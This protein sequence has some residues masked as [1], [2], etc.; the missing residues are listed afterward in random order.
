MTTDPREIVARGYDA[1]AEAYAEWASHSVTDPGRAEYEDH[2]CAL[3]G[4]G[5]SVLELGCGGGGPTTA[6]LAER[7]Q[8][9]GID[10][11]ESQITLARARLP[12]SRFLRADMTEFEAPLSSYDGIAAFHSLIHLPQGELPRM[13]GRIFGWLK[14]GGVFVASFGA[15]GSGEHFEPEWL[16]GQP[17]YWSGYTAADIGRFLHEAGFTTIESKVVSATEDGDE[18]PFRWVLATRPG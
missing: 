8:L 6:K 13:L 12:E 1:G 3:L 14:P 18:A 9:T 17:M 15:R 10:I 5:A 7:F 4:E 16:A 2:F 11:S